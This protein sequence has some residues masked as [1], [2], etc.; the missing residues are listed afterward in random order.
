MNYDIVV[1]LNYFIY[2]LDGCIK[3]YLVGFDN[4]MD[5]NEIKIKL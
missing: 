5:D 1:V 2:E 4:F 3:G